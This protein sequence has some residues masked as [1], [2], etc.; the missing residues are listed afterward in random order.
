MKINSLKIR[1]IMAYKSLSVSSLAEICGMSRQ[2]LSTILSRGSGTTV[3]VGK[4]AR[5]LGVAVEEIIV[6]E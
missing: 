5:G 6:K 4:I 1:C 3:T 2:G